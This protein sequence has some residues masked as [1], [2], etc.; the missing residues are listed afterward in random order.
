MLAGSSYQ[1]SATGAARLR[2]GRGGRG[3]SLR[4]RGRDALPRQN[5]INL[6]RGTSVA[7]TRDTAALLFKNVVA[8]HEFVVVFI[9]RFFSGWGD[10]SNVSDV[11]V[12]RATARY[13]EQEQQ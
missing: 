13:N 7:G 9:G 8:S 2:A 3:G 12:D 11:A 1:A 4:R 6:R 10:I 5:R